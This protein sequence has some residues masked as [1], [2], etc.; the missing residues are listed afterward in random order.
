[1]GSITTDSGFGIY[2][3]YYLLL[4]CAAENRSVK[5]VDCDFVTGE[6]GSITI[7]L[8]VSDQSGKIGFVSLCPNDAIRT[9][10]DIF[11]RFI[12]Y[13]SDFFTFPEHS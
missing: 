11:Y 13:I 2:Y 6:R 3:S 5:Y 7:S 1:M 4:T 9:L 8:A 12:L 10:V